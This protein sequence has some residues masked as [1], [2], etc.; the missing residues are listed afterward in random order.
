MPK[1][2]TN[3]FTVF[4]LLTVIVIVGIL[5]YLVFS[6]F[7]TESQK[8]H[9]SLKNIKDY[10]LKQ[11]N[12]NRIDLICFKNESECII[13]KNSEIVDHIHLFNNDDIRVYKV[14]GYN[15]YEY[16]FPKYYDNDSFKDVVFKYTINK[17]LSSSQYIV[18][19]QDTF[20]YLDSYFQ[21]TV[22]TFDDLVPATKEWLKNYEE[23]KG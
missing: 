2:I 10:L 7:K 1:K 8:K 18:E 9:I 13:K 6:N 19:Y 5:Y 21:K 4:E 17:N 16:T 3:A 11:Y 20:Y 15:A 22:K 14:Y 23:L 12:G